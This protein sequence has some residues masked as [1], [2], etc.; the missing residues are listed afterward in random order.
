MNKNWTQVT[1]TEQKRHIAASQPVFG[2][3]ADNILIWRKHT[4]DAQPAQ[5][6]AKTEFFNGPTRRFIFK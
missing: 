4:P 5:F 1:E 3:G 2:S 6:V